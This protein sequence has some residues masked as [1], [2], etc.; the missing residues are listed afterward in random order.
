MAQRVTVQEATTGNWVLFASSMLALLGGMQIIAGLVGIFNADFYVTTA[1]NLIVF[2][3][4]TWGWIHL[5]LGLVSMLAAVGILVGATWARI[6]GV[7]LA[8]LLML[9]HIVFLTAYPLWSIIAIIVNGLVIYAL[10]LHG[11][12]LGN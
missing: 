6:Y 2:N 9:G 8:T 1:N 12:E 3:Q 11:D 10:T 7:F 4:T 5:V